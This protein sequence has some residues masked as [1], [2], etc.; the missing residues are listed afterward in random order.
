MADTA[1]DSDITTFALLLGRLGRLNEA[2]VTDVCAGFDTTSAEV[3]VL[4]F[5]GHRPDGAASPSAIATFVVQTSGGLT[6]TLRR[7]ENDGY[8]ERRPD[9]R[10]GRGKLVALT[11]AG[12]Q[13]HAEVVAAISARTA[14]AVAALDVGEL[15]PVV[16]S[17]VDGLERAAGQPSSAGFVAGRIIDDID[18]LRS[19]I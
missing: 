14:A 10:D 19:N 2:L 12:R 18:S 8:V 1:L 3:R 15:D 17:L 7:L 11:D 6:A 16:R 13:F 9:P 5:L 4:A